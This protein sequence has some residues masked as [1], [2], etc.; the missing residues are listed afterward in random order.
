MEASSIEQ[1]QVDTTALPC[2]AECNA[3]QKDFIQE[4]V[5]GDEANATCIDY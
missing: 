3:V 4:K 1:S 2:I 5:Y